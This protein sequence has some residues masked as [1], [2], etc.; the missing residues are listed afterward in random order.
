VMA[1]GESAMV[2]ET[3]IAAL[4]VG[5]LRSGSWRGRKRLV[6]SSG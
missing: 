1:G 4:F 6:D 5:H 3:S 2:A